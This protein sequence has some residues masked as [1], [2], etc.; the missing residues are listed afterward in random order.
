MSFLL[1]R[2]VANCSKVDARK[3]S[4]ECVSITVHVIAREV[5][6]LVPACP[7][8]VTRDPGTFSSLEHYF[9]VP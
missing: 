3:L 6:F 4:E 8:R 7:V 1:V 2:G 5:L 9:T